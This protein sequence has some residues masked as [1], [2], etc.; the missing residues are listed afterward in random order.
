MN[1]LEKL[2]IRG[3]TILNLKDGGKVKYVYNGRRNNL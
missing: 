3:S 2:N 1:V